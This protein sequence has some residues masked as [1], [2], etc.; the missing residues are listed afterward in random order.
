MK[1][2]MILLLLVS[3]IGLP[4]ACSKG[5]SPSSPTS[6]PTNTFT[7]TSSP[8]VTGTPTATPQPHL[9]LTFYNLPASQ[10]Y[11]PNQANVTG[12]QFGFVN[13]GTEAVSITQISFGLG[14]SLT[15][16]EVVSASVRLFPDTGASG[17]DFGANGIYTGGSTAAVTS[18]GSFNSGSVTFK[19]PNGILEVAPGAPQTLLLVYSLNAG[20]G[21]ETFYNTVGSASVSAVG[22]TSG[23]ASVVYGGPFNGNTHTVMVNSPTVTNTSTATNTPSSTP[24]VTNT[25][26]VTSSPTPTYTRTPVDTKTPAFTETSTSTWTPG[27]PTL[28]FTNTPTVT[29]SPTSTKTPTTTWTPGGPTFTPTNTSTVTNSPTLTQTPTVTSTVT[30]T[31]TFV[32]TVSFSKQNTSVSDPNGLAVDSTGT[33][34]YVA[35]D[36]GTVQQYIS[37]SLQPTFTPGFLAEPGAVAINQG[38]GNIYVTDL[39]NQAVYEISSSG[40]SITGWTSYG[41]TGFLYP[42]GVALDNS[43]N[44]YV[45]DSGNNAVYEFNAS[46]TSTIAS[47]TTDGTNT[48]KQPSAVTSDGTHIYIADSGNGYIDEFPAGGGSLTNQVNSENSIEGSFFVGLALDGNGNIF[49]ADNYNSLVEVYS[50]STDNMTSQFGQ[51]L[52]NANEDFEYLTGVAYANSTVWTTDFQNGGGSNTGSLEQWGPG[53]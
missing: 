14:G 24:T 49:A 1:K 30:N 36:T 48:F 34:I 46:G 15:S 28:T 6:G 16:S 40:A 37:G 19:N 21:G 32:A 12:I 17:D 10:S 5:S 26:T 7:V 29:N 2:A 43:G 20:N 8:T 42:V 31:A 35:N 33:T 38:S 3:A 23:L 52:G 44:V 53:F 45:A 50:L 27:G 25:S 51:G 39:S 4:L 47:Y 13:Y 11:L 18:G 41:S 9:A 22:L